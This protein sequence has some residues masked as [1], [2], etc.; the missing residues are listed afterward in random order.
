MK[1]DTL[2]KAIGSTEESSFSEICRSLGDDCPERGDKEE[3]SE[4]F[5]LIDQAENNKLID[6]SWTEGR[7][8]G[9]ILTE[10]G[11]TRVRNQ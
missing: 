10:A 4:F 9:A 3:W 6:V 1:L 11:V 5:Q 8:D 7:L 2:L